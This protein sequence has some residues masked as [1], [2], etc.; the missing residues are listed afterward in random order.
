[1]IYIPGEDYFLWNGQFSDGTTGLWTLDPV[2]KEATSLL[3]YQSDGEF[4]L[5]MIGD[6]EKDA[7]AISSPII[8]EIDFGL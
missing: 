2:N 1:M 8:D 7:K 4:P 3:E 6:T 5:M